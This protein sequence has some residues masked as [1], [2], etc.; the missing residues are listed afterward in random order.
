[1]VPANP[2]IPLKISNLKDDKDH[3]D[4]KA[5]ASEQKWQLYPTLWCPTSKRTEVADGGVLCQ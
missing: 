2:G 3:L 1:M 5:A 4:T